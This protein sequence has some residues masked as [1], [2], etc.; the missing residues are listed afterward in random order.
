MPE[1][2]Q[3]SMHWILKPIKGKGLPKISVTNRII[4]RTNSCVRSGTKDKHRKIGNGWIVGKKQFNQCLGLANKCHSPLSCYWSQSS[5]LSF[6]F[7]F[8]EYDLSYKLNLLYFF[9][10]V[11]VKPKL[12]ISHN[13]TRKHI[14][15]VVN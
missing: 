10:L 8:K 1:V 9:N 14:I 11:L 15:K 12:V 13:Q 3:Y 4:V 7:L 6:C 2:K 5:L